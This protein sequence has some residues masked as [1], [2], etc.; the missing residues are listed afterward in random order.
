MKGVSLLAVKS[1]Y[2]LHSVAAPVLV[3]VALPAVY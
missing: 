3:F 2:L 1:D